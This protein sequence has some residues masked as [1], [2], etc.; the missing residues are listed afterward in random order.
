MAAVNTGPQY[1]AQ[2][3]MIVSA[4]NSDLYVRS[5]MDVQQTP[6]YDMVIIAAGSVLNLSTSAFFTNV[7]ANSGKGLWQT[8]MTQANQLASPEAFSIF[9]FRF[10]WSEDILRAD[11]TALLNGT[12]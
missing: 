3:A 8:N 9:Q 6:L 2:Q 7:G 5:Q 11:L 1:T 4:F 10:R 12:V